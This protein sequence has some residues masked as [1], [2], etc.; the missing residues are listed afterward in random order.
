MNV[1]RIKK[2]LNKTYR[3]K[4]NILNLVLKQFN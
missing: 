4:L 3:L 2:K 1:K